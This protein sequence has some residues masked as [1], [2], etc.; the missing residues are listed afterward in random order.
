MG[1]RLL[2]F[3]RERQCLR[4]C[5]STHAR[6]RAHIYT[7]R[8]GWGRQRE[9]E[10]E[11]ETC[12]GDGGAD[13]TIGG[14]RFIEDD[15]AGDDHNDTL[16]SV[17]HGLRVSGSGFGVWSGFRVLVWGGVSLGFREDRMSQRLGTR[18]R[19]M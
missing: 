8:W 2:G 3:I 1:L 13:H 16:H 5:V 14:E 17:A 19:K 7:H 10:R 4:L 18:I 9:R 6:A 11:R 12:D 15:S